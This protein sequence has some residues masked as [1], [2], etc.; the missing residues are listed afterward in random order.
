MSLYDK[1]SLVLIP[2]GTKAGKVFSQKP[3]PAPTG[4]ELVTNGTFDTDSNW[5]K[6]T[7]WT[8]ANGV[9]TYDN[10]GVA[11]NFRQNGF[12]EV[13]KTYILKFDTLE[14][15]G[16]NFGYSLGGNVVFFN[17]IE[18]NTTHQVKLV[19]EGENLRLRAADNFA[20]SKYMYVSTVLSYQLHVA[21]KHAN[22]RLVIL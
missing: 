7:G 5:T 20:G 10:D 22:F 11:G 17:S 14:T 16:G 9:A 1:A 2:S 13:G 8:I 4:V 18:A 3:V 6:D 12:L 19:A 15:N 21:I